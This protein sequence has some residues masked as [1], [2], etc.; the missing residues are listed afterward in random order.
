MNNESAPPAAAARRRPPT[1]A[2]RADRRRQIRLDV[3]VAGP[4]HAR[5]APRRGMPISRR[6]A[7]AR[8]CTRV[9]WPAGAVCGA[10]RSPTRDATARRSSPTTRSRVIAASERSRSSIDATGNPAAGIRHALACC[11]HGKH[12]VM[13]NVEA[14][15]LAGP[16]LARRAREA[17]VVYSLAYGD[18]PALICEMVD[19]AAP[20]ASRSSPPARARSICP[21]IT[22]RRPTTVWPHYGF[23]PEMVAARRL[24]RADVQFV[25]RRHEVARSRWRRSRTRP[26]S[27][28]APRRPRIS[29][30]RRR[31]SAARAAAR[32][33][34]AAC[35]ITRARSK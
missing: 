22:R 27:T 34:K 14:D 4:A 30:V 31:R 26:G 18:Q 19:W 23:T 7:H 20:R 6:R 13:V 1:V 24:Q 15:A 28:P 25:S 12:I 17:G 29:A 8:A 10:D 21:S 33:T 16:L 32:A 11:E 3:S 2:R 9:G 35:C 5:H